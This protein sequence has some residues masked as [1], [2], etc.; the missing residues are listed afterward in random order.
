MA[1]TYVGEVRNGVV[2]FD[3]TPAP[4]PEGTKVRV[5]PFSMESALD[6]L[7]AML[8]AVAGTASGLPSD[9]AENH[10]HYL[11][12]TPKRTRPLP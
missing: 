2:V 3:H 5:E 12:G 11:H 7:S 9:L 4:L 1:E 10:D 6:D 8:I